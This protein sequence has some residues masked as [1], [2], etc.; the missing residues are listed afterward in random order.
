VRLALRAIGTTTFERGTSQDAV[1]RPHDHEAHRTREQ[2]R[3]RQPR[4]NADLRGVDGRRDLLR[5]AVVI[6]T[7]AESPTTSR[8]PTV[9]V[10]TSFQPSEKILAVPDRRS[11]D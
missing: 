2:H 6:A 9:Q 11:C 5:L 7:I 4:G 10:P 8:L 1:R 3:S